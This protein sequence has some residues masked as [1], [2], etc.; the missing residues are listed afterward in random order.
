MSRDDSPNAEVCQT[1]P[2]ELSL[3]ELR[4]E[5]KQVRGQMDPFA[6][7]ESQRELA[8]RRQALWGEIRRRTDVH[9]PKCRKCGGQRWSQNAGDP[10]T[11]RDCG[12]EGQASTENAVHEAWDE[13]LEESA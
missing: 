6:P 7:Y 8:D 1:D 3:E 9:L 4:E 10:V 13:M 2:E 5:F 11:C 12:H